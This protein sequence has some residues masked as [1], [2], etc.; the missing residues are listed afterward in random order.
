M[1]KTGQVVSVVVMDVDVAR[2]R[3]ALSMKQG[4]K[5]PAAAP[6]K[7]NAA[8]GGKAPA[9]KDPPKPADSPFSVLSRL[10]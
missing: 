10:K 1:V 7:G 5:R 9:A 4:G 6:D 3:I 2:K 8:P